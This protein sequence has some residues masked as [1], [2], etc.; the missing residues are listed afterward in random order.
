LQVVSLWRCTLSSTPLRA[1]P[2]ATDSL[3]VVEHCRVHGSSTVHSIDPIGSNC[4]FPR[5]EPASAD[6][7]MFWPLLPSHNSSRFS[8]RVLC[9]EPALARWMQRCRPQGILRERRTAATRGG[10]RRAPPFERLER[11][12][13]GVLYCTCFFHALLMVPNGCSLGAGATHGRLGS[14]RIAVDDGDGDFCRPCPME[15]RGRGHAAGGSHAGWLSSRQSLFSTL[16]GCRLW[17]SEDR[18]R[19]VCECRPQG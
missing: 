13:V 5:T 2:S 11:R 16:G 9:A 14:V 19:W 6:C 17:R 12:V 15:R 18:R 3:P 1:G 10:S 4:P 7:N 8:R